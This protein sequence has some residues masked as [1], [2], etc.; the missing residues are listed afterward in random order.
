[1]IP[2]IPSLLFLLGDV[3]MRVPVPG[4]WIENISMEESK[5]AYI[6]DHVG[7]TRGMEIEENWN[8]LVCCQVER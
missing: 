8:V 5:P 7:S 3:R 2:F 6:L 1:M 4:R